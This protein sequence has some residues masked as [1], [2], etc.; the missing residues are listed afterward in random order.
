MTPCVSS[1]AAGRRTM[2]TEA[3]LPAQPRLSRRREFLASS[4][5]ASCGLKRIQFGHL[6]EALIS[7][8]AMMAVSR[9]CE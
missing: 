5:S 4:D 2:P 3:S 1:Q 7:M 9:T 8:G 6:D